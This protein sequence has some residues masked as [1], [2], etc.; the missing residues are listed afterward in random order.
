MNAASTLRTCGLSVKWPKSVTSRPV[1]AA[2]DGA[3]AS[4]RAY[5][6]QSRY[7]PRQLALP[8][9]LNIGHSIHERLRA[10]KL[11]IVQ[12]LEKQGC[13]A[14]HAAWQATTPDVA[15]GVVTSMVHAARRTGS[16]LELATLMLKHEVILPS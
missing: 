8:N 10:S 14:A 1:I 9:D 5:G 6:A 7:A 11:E 3:A 12:I 2:Y 4:L 15:R 13:S 16:A